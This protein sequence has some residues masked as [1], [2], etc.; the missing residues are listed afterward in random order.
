MQAWV[1]P[2]PLGSRE[3]IS[4]HPP[5]PRLTTEHWTAPQVLATP[6]P[7]REPLRQRQAETEACGVPPGPAG[8][9]G[10]EERLSEK[11]SSGTIL[12]SRPA[13]PAATP[14]GP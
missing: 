3:L 7:E 5:G 11:D 1:L 14:S 12:P 10:W 8:P 4:P 13:A 6:R 2:P 9:R